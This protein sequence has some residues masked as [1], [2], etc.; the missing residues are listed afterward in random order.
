MSTALANIVEIRGRQA[1]TNSLIVAEACLVT[2]QAALKL[3]RKYKTDFEELG[4]LDFEIRPFDTPGGEQRREIYLLSEDQATYLILLF[5]NTAK[6]RE[7]K[8]TLVK[9]FRR[10]LNVIARRF[11]NPPRAGILTDKR[12][13]HHPMMDALV[14]WR[15]D[16]GKDTEEHHFWCENKLCNGIVTGAFKAID[17]KGLSNADAELLTKVR[18][19]NESYILA[20]MDYPTRK[21]KL[22]EFA[23][24]QRTRMI[25]IEP[26]NIPG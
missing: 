17:E 16:Q 3:L 5:R 12:A 14:E 26:S 2:H 23:I 1:L 22:A 7:F 10:A 15:S 9:A 19:R 21:A 13:A 6:T 4:R 18:R 11:E 8:L 24:R 20:G 25:S